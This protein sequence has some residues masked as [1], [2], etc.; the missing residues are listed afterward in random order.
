MHRHAVTERKVRQVVTGPLGIGRAI[1][2]R[3]MHQ[4]Q[5]ANIVAL[6]IY[7]LNL[8]RIDEFG[9]IT[10][11]NLIYLCHLNDSGRGWPGQ[12]CCRMR[13]FDVSSY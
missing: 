11:T 6:M 5:V 8:V 2:R 7:A 13:V 1:Q 12:T 10:T 3:A 9:P 4:I